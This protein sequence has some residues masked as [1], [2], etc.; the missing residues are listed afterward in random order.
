MLGSSEICGPGG[1]PAGSVGEGSLFVAFEE[2]L[3]RCV[4]PKRSDQL[5]H[6]DTSRSRAIAGTRLRADSP[7]K[8]RNGFDSLLESGRFNIQFRD[9]RKLH[10]QL[11]GIQTI[12]TFRMTVFVS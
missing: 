7:P 12:I 4:R 10:V 2:S 11:K 5:T 3:V 1:A 8:S 9:N 6:P